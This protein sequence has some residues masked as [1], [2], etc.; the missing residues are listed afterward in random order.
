MRPR[1][2]SPALLETQIDALSKELDAAQRDLADADQKA[3][4]AEY[5]YDLAFAEAMVRGEG[6][7]A[8]IRKA[9]ALL[10]TKERA[11]EMRCAQQEM[12]AA[13]SRMQTLERRI[14][15]GRSLL[16]AQKAAWT[17]QVAS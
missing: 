16:S 14:E 4:K 13:K 11:W 12:R 10:A 1:D 3:T 8:E 17:G 2:V 6:S 9:D 15:V 7:N 5:D